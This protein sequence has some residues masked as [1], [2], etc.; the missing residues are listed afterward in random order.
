MGDAIL[1][2][3]WTRSEISQRT[4]REASIDELAE[5][6]EMYRQAALR[7][8]FGELDGIEVTM[9]HGMLLASFL[10]PLMNQ[11][12]DKYGGDL[13]K[14][15]LF[16]R[17]VLRAVRDAI[18]PDAILG[19]RIPGDELVEGG[20]RADEAANIARRL[21]QT[22]DVDYVSV[23]AGNNTRKLARVE[24]WPPT[25]APFGAFRHLSRR[26]KDVVSVPVATVGR[27][28][29]LRLAEEILLAGDAD[30]V[31]MVRAHVADPGLMPKSRAGAAAAVRP[32]VGANVCIN[33]LLDHKPLTCM[34]NP[35]VGRPGR[36]VPEGWGEGR[37][38]VV[39]GAG[40]AGLEAAR[41]LA[42]GGWRTTIIEHAKTLGGQMALWAATP[43][44]AE[45]GRLIDW[46]EQECARLGIAIHSGHPAEAAAVIARGPDLVVIATGSTPVVRP[47]RQDGAEVAQVGPYDDIPEGS[48]VLL[49]DE[50]GGLAALLTAERLSRRASRVTLVTSLLHPGEGDGITTVYPLLRDLAARGVRIVD[51]AK[52]S[53]IERRRAHLVGTFGE[54]RPV[55]EDVDVLVCVINVVSRAELVAPLRAAGLATLVI[56]DAHLPR[57]VTS[58]VAHAARAID[59]LAEQ[60]H[61]RTDP[62]QARPATRLT[63]V[64]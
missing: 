9:A 37:T 44:R 24:H 10:S 64:V 22:G 56:G 62:G 12:I 53:R 15:T 47:V 54:E 60:A 34:A 17:E 25:P 43:S 26:V 32:C 18:G 7:C 40:P 61:G 48:H 2:A 21:V 52:V 27:V 36:S 5:I 59:G 8:R 31:G 29:T 1:S 45:F 38:A 19:I 23:T 58:A 41:R 63:G 11:R 6:T 42:I 3:S 35:D 28:T 33:S 13:D 49:R 4:S 39:V 57:N 16:P 20:I 30:L 46:W 50:M 51:R 14:R 55:I